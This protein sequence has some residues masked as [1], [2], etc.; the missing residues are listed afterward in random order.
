MVFTAMNALD[1]G[2]GQERYE[3]AG[4]PII[5][6]LLIGDQSVPIMHPA[7]IRSILGMPPASDEAAACLP[8]AWDLAAV[9]DDWVRLLPSFTW[10]QLNE[11]TLSRGRSTRN[12]TV[13]TFRP[14]AMLPAAW[15]AGFF[16]WYTGEADLQQE[17]LLR[18]AEELEAFARRIAQ[19]WQGFLLES[20]EALVEGDPFISA[21][22]GDGPYSELL[23]AQRFHA[24]FHHRQILHFMRL[25]DIEHE[26]QLDVNGIADIGLPE[27]LY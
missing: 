4:K 20:N 2:V 16:E 26:V 15:T 24:A 12:L 13:N 6:T 22:R 18:S 7:Q 27:D 10:T 9:L 25:H 17:A 1:G 19:D 11:P 21:H 14:I 3:R 23:R 8:I 5:P